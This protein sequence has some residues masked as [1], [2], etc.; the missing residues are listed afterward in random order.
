MST[1]MLLALA[2]WVATLAVAVA[3]L[4]APPPVNT[5]AGVLQG[6]QLGKTTYY[7][8]VPFAEKPLGTL[9]FASPVHKAPWAGTRKALKFG[10]DC[11][12]YKSSDY[13]KFSNVSEDCLYLNVYVPSGATPSSKL[14]VMHFLYG[15]SWSWGGSS[16]AIYDAA[17]VV[18][19]RGNVIFVTSNYRLGMFGYLGGAALAKENADG[20][21]GNYGLQDQRMAM[22]WIKQNIAAFGGDPS[23]IMLFGQSAGAGS[24]AAHMIMQRSAGLFQRAGME[25]GPPCDWTA[26][27]LANAEAKFAKLCGLAGCCPGGKTPD[28]DSVACLRAK[29]T[30]EIAELSHMKTSAL[31]DWSPVIDGVEITEDPQGLWAQG[32]VAAQLGSSSLRIGTRLLRAE[33]VAGRRGDNQG[34]GTCFG[35]DVV[36]RCCVVTVLVAVVVTV[37]VAVV[38][39]VWA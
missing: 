29:N 18:A 15:G 23:N 9:R 6:G 27:P 36:P 30:T 3:G 16:F 2:A 24:V 4:G 5:S 17:P 28:A 26:T 21:T 7:L 22:E 33:V 31:I 25:S 34:A 37:V 20:S 8:G 11:A 38:V 35:G 1:A 10:P 32:R 12:T 13:V 39:T 19:E 14:P